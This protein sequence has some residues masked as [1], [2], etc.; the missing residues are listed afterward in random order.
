MCE[1]LVDVTQQ[2]VQDASEQ[3]KES[4]DAFGV[5]LEAHELF[6]RNAL[7]RTEEIQNQFRI[8]GRAALQIG[9]QLEF[10]EGKRQRCENAAFLIRRWWLL[11]SLA[12]QEALSGEPLKVQEEVRGVIP[13]NSCKM[14]PLFTQPEHSLEA[15]KALRQ[16]RQVVKSRG[17][18]NESEGTAQRRFDLTADL[19]RRTSEALEQRLLPNRRQ[20]PI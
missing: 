4:E 15:S 7:V 16:L 11:E 2:I 17:N 9:T 18:S 19:I 10:A 1:T 6:A 3:I 14:D 20:H 13:L 8:N 5:R 12:E